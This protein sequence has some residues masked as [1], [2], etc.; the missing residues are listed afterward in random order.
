[1][2]LTEN[3]RQIIVGMELEKAQKTYEDFEIMQRE[4]RWSS[5]A[6]RLY[7]ALFHAISALLIHDGHNVKSHRG[8]QALF[9]L[10][11]VRT[12]IFTSDDGRVLTDLMIMRDNAD[13]NCFYEAA[14]Q[15]VMPNIEPTRLLI[16]KIR[17]YIAN[18]RPNIDYN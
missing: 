1:M 10:H 3:E 5:A 6:N 13:Y 7:Y 16:E 8:V 15:N 4:E 2:S 17:H 9:G 18:N 14:K 12:G 11:Y